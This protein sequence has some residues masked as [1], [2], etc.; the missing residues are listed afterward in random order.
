LDYPFF[1]RRYRNRRNFHTTL[2]QHEQKQKQPIFFPYKY[3]AQ[4]LLKL[5]Q[6]IFLYVPSD[7]IRLVTFVQGDHI[8][9]EGEFAPVAGEL[10]IRA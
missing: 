1:L 6:V 3:A 7:A 9:L 2:A 4:F 8:M 5:S 10:L